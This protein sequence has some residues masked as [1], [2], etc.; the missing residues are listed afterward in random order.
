MAVYISKATQY[1]SPPGELVLRQIVDIAD[2]V[3]TKIES[4]SAPTAFGRLTL[5]AF[6]FRSLKLNLYLNLS[7]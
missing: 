7:S 1:L 4:V 6:L 3:S 2:M 5:I